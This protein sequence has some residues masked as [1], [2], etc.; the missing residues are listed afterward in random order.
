MDHENVLVPWSDFLDTLEQ[1]QSSHLQLW[2]RRWQFNDN[3]A[4]LAPDHA[5][6]RF[7]WLVP[8][9]ARKLKTTITKPDSYDP[10]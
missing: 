3:G 8:A 1:Q 7:P 5:A 9:L 4:L 10:A 6:L 2:L